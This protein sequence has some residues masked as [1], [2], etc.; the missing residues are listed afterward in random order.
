MAADILSGIGEKVMRFFETSSTIATSADASS[1][2][3]TQQQPFNFLYQFDKNSSTE[4]TFQELEKRTRLR[5]E[6]IVGI[7]VSLLA[8]YMAI[9]TL[10]QLVFYFIGVLWPICASVRTIQ[11]D[12][13]ALSKW[14]TYWTGFGTFF[15]ADSLFLEPI[16][17]GFAL[18]WLSKVIFVL[19]LVLPQTNGS[20]EFFD[21]VVSPLVVRIDGFVTHFFVKWQKSHKNLTAEMGESS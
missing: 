7:F 21:K 15:I 4:K 2:G 11:T 9:G 8:I 5:R 10:P 6:Q 12:R 20:E 16:F 17:S 18:Y 13:E 14:L 19:Y 1:T 3:R